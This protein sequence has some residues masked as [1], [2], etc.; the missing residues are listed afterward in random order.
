MIEGSNLNSVFS[1]LD[2]KLFE[3]KHP[4]T[5]TIFGSSALIAQNFIDRA[6][7]DVDVIDPKLDP[8]FQVAA[9]EIAPTLGLDPTWLNS[10]G[11][12]FSR[13]LP[14]GWES[15]TQVIFRG[16]ALKVKSLSRGDLILTKFLS[17]CQR[18]GVD[19]EDLA[20]MKPSTI[21]LKSAK[22]WALQRESTPEWPTRVDTVLEKVKGLTKGAKRELGR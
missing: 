9:M 10:A 1:A 13:H 17:A 5:I 14:E 2:K 12:V 8:Q 4:K 6:T 20:S 21:E 16:D 19:S 15:R 18:V 11:T 7:H 3:L 22:K